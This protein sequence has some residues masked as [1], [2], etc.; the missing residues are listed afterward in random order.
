MKGN[1]KN[2][3]L[4]GVVILFCFLPLFSIC[5]F[6]FPLSHIDDYFVLWLKLLAYFI[7]AGIVGYSLRKVSDR[8]LCVGYITIAVLYI[9]AFVMM[10]MLSIEIPILG[11]FM[12][13]YGVELGL[14]FLL[15]LLV[16]LGYASIDKLVKHLSGGE[17]DFNLERCFLI[18]AGVPIIVWRIDYWVDGIDGFMA[19][20]IV[21]LLV[22]RKFAIVISGL[23]AGRMLANILGKPNED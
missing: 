14:I 23:V 18:M 17:R 2:I 1:I 13:T 10:G 6:E 22:A 20:N 16:M 11:S 7:A 8:R 19:Y 4:M 9:V 3:V 21:T 5:P 12:D 15:S